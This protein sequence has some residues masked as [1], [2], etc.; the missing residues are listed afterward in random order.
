MTLLRALQLAFIATALTAQTAQFAHA[1][2]SDILVQAVDGRLVTGATLTVPPTAVLG[3]RAFDQFFDEGFAV[4]EPG[5][6]SIGSTTGTLPPGS[7]ALPGERDMQ[8]DFVPMKVNGLASNLLYWNGVGSTPEQV[9]FGPAPTGDYSFSLF[10]QDDARFAADGSDQL[11]PGGVIGTTHDDGGLH[12][13]HFYLLDDDHDDENETIAAEGIYL[14]ALRLRMAELNRSAPFYLV[15]G[16][17]AASVDALE[18]AHA[19]AED[20]APLLSPDFEA[21]FDGDLDVD[22]FD[23]LTWQRHVG[24]ASGALQVDG[25][26]NQDHAVNAADLEVLR[27]ELGSSMATFVG[28]P[29]VATGGAVPEPSTAALATVAVASLMRRRRT[30]VP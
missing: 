23:F 17:P 13:D 18:T 26:A 19:W 20:R 24:T 21:D 3:V 2:H 7:S 10:A 6:Q 9:A 5:F 30:A 29:W 14:V 1:Q 22:G 25:D 27:S 16:T 28:V 12:E 11:V 4:D 15:W 8:F